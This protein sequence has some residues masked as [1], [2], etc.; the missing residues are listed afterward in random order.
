MAEPAAAPVVL[1]LHGSIMTKLLRAL[2]D[3][4]AEAAHARGIA[5]C[6]GR[7]D[8]AE[9]EIGSLHTADAILANRLA[10][11]ICEPHNDEHQVLPALVGLLAA[12]RST[13]PRRP[14]G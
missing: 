4:L 5:A 14:T 10:A 6:N 12:L 11:A 9:C 1:D 7:D 3:S 2:D 8:S 13:F